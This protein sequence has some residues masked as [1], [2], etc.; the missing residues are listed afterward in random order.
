MSLSRK[1]RPCS[2]CNC[3]VMR[4]DKV[5]TATS[6]ISRR[7][8]STPISS[9]SSASIIEGVWTNVLDVVVPSCQF[10]KHYKRFHVWWS[11]RL[12]RPHYRARHTYVLDLLHC[13]VSIRRYTNLFWLYVYDDQQRV[14]CVALEQLVDLQVRCPQLGACVIPT[15]ELLPGVD[16]LKHIVHRLDIVVI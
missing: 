2:D 5:P 12:W 7:R 14:W 9:A 15:D 8:C 11:Q 10:G 16:L 6:R 4:V 3:E 1:C 13:K